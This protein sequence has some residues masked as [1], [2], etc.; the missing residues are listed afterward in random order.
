MVD[1]E[2]FKDLI[3]S[4]L[5]MIKHE[6]PGFHLIVEGL[7]K[8]CDDFELG[9]TNVDVLLDRMKVKELK[10]SVRKDS[11]L[12]TSTQNHETINQAYYGY[13]NNHRISLRRFL[14]NKVIQNV[15]SMI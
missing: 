3:H 15:I 11:V 4:L 7:E 5:I 1:Y 8:I 6:F 10:K 12:Y 2:E 13:D 14:K 9:M